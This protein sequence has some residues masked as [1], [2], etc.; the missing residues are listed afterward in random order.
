MIDDVLPPATPRW[1]LM[2]LVQSM[3]L[4]YSI[5]ESETSLQEL[6]RGQRRLLAPRCR[7]LVREADATPYPSPLLVLERLY[8]VY[9]PRGPPGRSTTPRSQRNAGS[10]P[11]A[12]GRTP[13]PGHSGPRPQGCSHRL[14]PRSMPGRRL[15]ILPGSDAPATRLQRLPAG[16][17]PTASRLLA[18]ATTVSRTSGFCTSPATMAKP[19]APAP[20]VCPQ[21]WPRTNGAS[22]SSRKTGTGR[23]TSSPSDG[24]SGQ[25]SRPAV[26][27][28][29]GRNQKNREPKH[30]H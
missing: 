30:L 28:P 29:K 27:T 8:H 1:G 23:A 4:D 16:A 25:R 12:P 2:V 18:M 14:L 6:A 15:P 19:T 7:S 22:G 13:T 24:P 26:T 20:T 17:G 10:R 3:S 5:R 11:A 21:A 9:P